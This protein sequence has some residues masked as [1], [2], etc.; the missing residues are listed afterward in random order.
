MNLMVRLACALLNSTEPCSISAS[1]LFFRA[2]LRGLDLQ[3]EQRATSTLEP[4]ARLPDAHPMKE[5]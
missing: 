4:R 3:L 2:K 5:V 1:A